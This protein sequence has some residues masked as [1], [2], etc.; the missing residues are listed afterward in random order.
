MRKIQRT[1]MAVA[2]QASMAALF[3]GAVPSL[4]CAQVAAS[5]DWKTSG[6]ASFVSDYV[7]RGVS[8]T[9]GKPAAQVSVTA[10]HASGAY[11]SFFASNVAPQFVPNANLET[12]WSLGYKTKMSGLDLDVG[13]IFI[14]YPGGNF[15]NTF[16]GSTL[17]PSN[18][19]T[20]E[21]YVS[22]AASGA[23]LRFGYIPGRFFG[24][25]ENNSGVGNFNANEPTAGLKTDSSSGAWALDAS[26]TLAVTEGWSLQFAVGHQE[27]PKSVETSW[28]YGRLALNGDL[29]NSWSMNVAASA[30]TQPKS[31][32]NFPSLT[33]NGQEYS[34]AKSKLIL[35]LAKAF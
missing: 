2:S 18:P 30:T 29:G 24:W 3:A 27:V 1:L 35:T 8:Q 10:D 22:A 33:G 25:N 5:S 12:D 26:Y 16:N 15:K 31:F 34:P 7:F 14:Y 21:L 6:Q 20:L 28:S 23:S 13:G 32:K 9:W 4:V 17:N 11:A 19:Q